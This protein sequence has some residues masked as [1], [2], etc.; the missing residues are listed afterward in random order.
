MAPTFNA[1]STFN[2]AKTSLRAK[3]QGHMVNLEQL[4]DFVY[5]VERRRFSQGDVNDESIM[6]S[7]KYDGKY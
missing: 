1:A 3:L 7:M 5:N 2:A 4:S 6:R